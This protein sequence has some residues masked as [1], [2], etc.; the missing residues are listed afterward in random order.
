M[1]G[2]ISQF[3]S[4]GLGGRQQTHCNSI[5]TYISQRVVTR[6]L[7]T[8]VLAGRAMHRCMSPLCESWRVFALCVSTIELLTVPDLTDPSGIYRHG[9]FLVILYD[10]TVL[11]VTCEDG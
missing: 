5:Y 9:W 4:Q 6:P 10:R 11:L 8:G 1:P 3:K 2:I 7:E